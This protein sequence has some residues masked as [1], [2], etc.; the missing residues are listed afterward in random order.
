MAVNQ[1]AVMNLD[2]FMARYSDEGPFEL[3]TGEMLPVTPQ[4]ARSGRVGGRLF[5]HLAAY[6]EENALGE[7]FIETPF[8]LLLDNT[9]WVK[10]SRVPDVMFYSAE[11]LTTLAAAVPDWEDKPLIGV[12]DF[13]AEVVSPTDKFSTVNAKIT[14]YLRDG[15]RLLWLIEPEQQTVTVYA[16]DSN[17]QMR[18]S[19]LD[20]TL[21]GDAVIP[22]YTIKLADLF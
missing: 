9:Q 14:T 10:G 17:Q 6:V 2:D 13:V 7:V 15:V 4:I 22:G 16:G 20:S 21:S 18:I 3:V 5:R 11:K 12:P 1:T 8:V 19:G